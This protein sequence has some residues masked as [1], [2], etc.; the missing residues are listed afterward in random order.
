MTDHFYKIFFTEV[1]K[2]RKFE[3]VGILFPSEDFVN[4]KTS[5]SC[6]GLRYEKKR[7]NRYRRKRPKVDA[8]IFDSALSHTRCQDASKKKEGNNVVALR[9]LFDVLACGQVSSPRLYRLTVRV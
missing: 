8:S 2:S 7:F 5:I 9:S 4:R 6:N 1:S 3:K